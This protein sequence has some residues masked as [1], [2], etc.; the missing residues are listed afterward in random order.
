MR[1]GCVSATRRN[2]LT[3]VDVGEWYTIEMRDGRT[4]SAV[5]VL[6]VSPD[7]QLMFCCKDSTPQRMM[8]RQVDIKSIGVT[9]L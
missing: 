7:G 2:M 4:W 6:E 5:Q 9:E 1:A 8:V 3:T